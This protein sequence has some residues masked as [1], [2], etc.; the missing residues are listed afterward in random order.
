V[1]STDQVRTRPGGRNA[2]VRARVFDAVR[3]AL[4]SG[5]PQNLSFDR[6]AE[7]AGVHR[8][9][10]YRRWLSTEG[11]VADLLVELTPL[12]TPLPDTGTLGGDLAEVVSRVAATA[13]T[14]AARMMQRLVA[15]TTDQYLVEAA[16]GYWSSLLDH[17]A[18]VIRRAQRRGAAAADVDPVVA[19]ESLLAPI[20]FRLLVTQQPITDEFLTERVDH[21]I[22][23]LTGP[24]ATP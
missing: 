11:L 23:L 14:P 13:A 4:E 19:T 7:Q 9:T 18:Q 3:Q 17:T 20:H 1:T 22:R 21:T 2:Q 12:D 10:I 24:A 16:R 8:A 5:D 6:L 15:G